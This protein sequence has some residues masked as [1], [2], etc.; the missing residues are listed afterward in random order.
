MPF[1]SLNFSLVS[2]LTELATYI[3]HS[4][5]GPKSSISMLVCPLATGVNRPA[6]EFVECLVLS[7][8]MHLATAIFIRD[9]CSGQGCPLPPACRGKGR[10]GG[11]EE[12][13]DC[14]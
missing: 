4:S 2:Y 11:L 10:G 12:E 14:S 13:E 9:I 1:Y 7:E 3:P 8:N 6:E 5:R